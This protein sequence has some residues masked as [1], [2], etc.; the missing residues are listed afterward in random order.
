MFNIDY[1][2]IQFNLNLQTVKYIQTQTGLTKAKTEKLKKTIEKNVIQ[3]LFASKYKIWLFNE[4]ISVCLLG[5]N[6][7]D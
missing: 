6:Y 2:H 4:H 5:R 1:T 3:T 7:A